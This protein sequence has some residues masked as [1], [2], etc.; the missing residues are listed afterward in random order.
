MED[1]LRSLGKQRINLAYTAE[2]TGTSQEFDLMSTQCYAYAR[3]MLLDNKFMDEYFDVTES[4]S[5]SGKATPSFFEYLAGW[6]ARKNISCEINRRLV[7][8]PNMSPNLFDYHMLTAPE[9][10]I[11]R[12]GDNAYR[13]Q[14]TRHHRSPLFPR[15][16]H[17]PPGFGSTPLAALRKAMARCGL[18][19]QP[20]GAVVFQGVANTNHYLTKNQVSKIL[21]NE[22]MF[23]LSLVPEIVD[24]HDPLHDAYLP[25]LYMKPLHT[26]KTHNY[27]AW[28]HFVD[29][30][31]MEAGKKA[32]LDVDNHRHFVGWQAANEHQ[33]R[34]LESHTELKRYDIENNTK[35]A[36]ILDAIVRGV[37]FMTR[38]L[39]CEP[40]WECVSN[41]NGHHVLHRHHGATPMEAYA[42]LV[43]AAKKHKL[44]MQ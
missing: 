24:V 23:A 12:I 43:E 13:A 6:V 18:N 8:D 38:T 22:Q 19:V 35:H 37:V 39:G 29:F 28:R 10:S 11:V 42:S 1:V 44:S 41:I 16:D 25:Q 15:L 36:S 34:L 17:Y 26:V 31:S 30:C 7:E 5:R 4:V 32:G 21:L 27:D 9:W 14:R 33:S 3:R 40:K 20:N 2:Q